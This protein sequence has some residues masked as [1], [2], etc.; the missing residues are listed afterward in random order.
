M[1][2]D[3]AALTSHEFEPIRHTYARRDVILYA[4]G[5]GVGSVDPCDRGE[6]RYVFEKDLVAMPTLAV[7]LGLDISWFAVPKFNIT[8]HM[9]LHAEQSLTLHRP[10][11]VEGTVVSRQRIEAA[12]D[13]GPERGAIL[14]IR[15]ELYDA[16]T[17]EHLAS[18][19]HLMA[20]RADGGFGGPNRSLPLPGSIPD[21][22]DPDLRLPLPTSLNQALIYRLSGDYNPLH[23]DP[24]AARAGGFDRPIL[25]G[26]A[27]YGMVGRALTKA[28][29]DDDA[30]RFRRLDIRFTSPVYPGE[31]LHAEVGRTGS[32]EAAVRLVASDRNQVV[33]DFG[34]FEFAE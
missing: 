23:A 4:L 27:A 29:C 18:V 1:A 11:P 2:L 10:L 8:F 28:L 25:H 13:K 3:Y 14:D 19:G 24:V 31:P 16:A 34:R 26:L 21:D 15:R 5:L 7:V 6:L 17:D 33:E 30:G 12:Y 22:R 32:G 9:L 20:L